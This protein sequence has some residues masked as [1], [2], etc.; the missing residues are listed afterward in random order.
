M[1]GCL[2]GCDVGIDNGEKGHSPVGLWQDLEHAFVIRLAT[3][4]CEKQ[5]DEVLPRQLES[6]ASQEE[7]L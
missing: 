3:E 2:D 7:Q 1:K 4:S 6:A 5:E